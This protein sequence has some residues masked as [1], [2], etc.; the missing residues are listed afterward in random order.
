[1]HVIH[2]ALHGRPYNMAVD[3]DDDDGKPRSELDNKLEDIMA[4]LP[5]GA[6]IVRPGD[7]VPQQPSTSED[8]NETRQQRDGLE[9]MRR[10]LNASERLAKAEECKVQA[11]EHFAHGKWRVSMVGYV[12]GI[13]FL[14]HG[15]PR[16]PWIVASEVRGLDEVVTS[17]GAGERS[18]GAAHSSEPQDE[19]GAAPLR[20]AC[21][22]NLA[23]AALKMS[24]W[25]IARAAC[26][27]VLG[28]DSTNA[29]ALFR[30]AKAHEG[31][32]DLAA[33]CSTVSRLLRHDAAN[34]EARRLLEALRKRQAKEKK[35]FAGC[36]ERVRA[37]E[38][39][40]GLYTAA[41][42]RRDKQEAKR[43]ADEE[44]AE[45]QKDAPDGAQVFSGKQFAHMS[46]EEQ[47][48]F[49]DDVNASL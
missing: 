15:E 32:G 19:D 18:A 17:L 9:E 11:N 12:A 3:D 34:A 4:K 13:F 31:A 38:G 23:A 26:E 49:V 21:H 8:P 47:Q 1:M 25:A 20:N 36:F 42:E 43:R 24:E 30:L 28:V 35:A 5:P 33:A 10:S 27:Y 14:K 41:E 40:E 45:M 22:L 6:K 44:A 39:G 48:R 29:K 37:A 7:P 2:V 46:P 16:C